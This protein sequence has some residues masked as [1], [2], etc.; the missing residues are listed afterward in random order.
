MAGLRRKMP[1][2]FWAMTL[3]G[4]SLAGFPLFSGFWSKDAIIAAIGHA[5]L[6][7]DITPLLY[8]FALATVFMTAFYTMRAIT[9]TFFGRWRGDAHS[10]D[11]VHESPP[12][13]LIPM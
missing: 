13:M 2:T 5:H 4:L 9:L 10:F 6:P 8:F 11:H 12:A 7:V 1:G 3:A